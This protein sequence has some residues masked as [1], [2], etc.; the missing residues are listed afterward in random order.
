MNIDDYGEFVFDTH[1][2][3]LIA[4]YITLQ[5]FYPK[6]I[7]TAIERLFDAGIIMRVEK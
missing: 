3:E 6:G 2:D 7:E 5:W 4:W 1:G